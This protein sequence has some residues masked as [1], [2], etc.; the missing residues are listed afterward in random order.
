MHKTPMRRT[1]ADGNYIMTKNAN[2]NDSHLYRCDESLQSS[3]ASFP[4]AR[5]L[6]NT[7]LCRLIPELLSDWLERHK[8]PVCKQGR[9]AGVCRGI[10]YET[11]AK[12]VFVL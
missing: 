4:S 7:Q 3:H 11:D 9:W 8:E 1:T 2:I 10:C 12:L 5:C 6:P